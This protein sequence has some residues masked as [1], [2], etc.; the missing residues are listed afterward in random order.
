VVRID[1]AAAITGL[2]VVARRFDYTTTS[3]PLPTGE[4]AQ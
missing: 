4:G 3:P 2:P 1:P